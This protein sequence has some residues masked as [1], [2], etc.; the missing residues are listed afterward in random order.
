M[1]IVPEKTEPDRSIRGSG[2]GMEPRRRRPP[3]GNLFAFISLAYA[4]S[5]I[6]WLMIIASGRDW[7]SFS[8]PL[9]PFGGFAPGLAAICVA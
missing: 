8:V 2:V 9:T 3:G 5:W 6:Y 7:F 1:K 4:L